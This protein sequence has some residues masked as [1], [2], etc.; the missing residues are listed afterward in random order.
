MRQDN[1][2]GSSRSVVDLSP[3][4]RAVLIG[5]VLGDGCLAKH[6]RHHR[7]HVKHKLAHRALAEFKRE[8]FSDFVTMP[9]H[10]FDQRLGGKRFPCVQFASRTNPVFSRWHNRFYK[11]GR[12]IVPLD[13]ASLLCPLTVAVWL[14]DDGAADYAGVTFQTHSFLLEEV[15]LL[16]TALRERFDLATGSRRN[17]SGWV[18]YVPAA[19][20]KTLSDLV[21]PHLLE[22][23]G[24]KLE[25]RRTRTP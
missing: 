12:K 7:L 13:I 4:Q 19:S 6:G 24:Y 18:I 5:T 8:V 15:E 10:E 11:D 9:L 17:K 20:V 2:E 22:G 23:F 16:I 14:M 25:P 21:S 3:Q 1:A